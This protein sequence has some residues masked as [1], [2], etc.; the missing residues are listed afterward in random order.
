MTRT[1]CPRD[2]HVVSVSHTDRQS[3]YLVRTEAPILDPAWEVSRLTLE[4]LVL[5]YMSGAPR[6]PDPATAPGGAPMI[7]LTWRQFRVSALAVLG[8]L[9]AARPAHHHRAPA[10]G[11]VPGHGDDFFDRLSDDG[12]RR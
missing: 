3:T 1:R 4:D 7:W 11:P 9:A 6:Q 8:A 5:A 10:R 12:S 2:Q